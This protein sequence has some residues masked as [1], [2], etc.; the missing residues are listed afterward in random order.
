MLAAAALRS[1][2]FLF[3]EPEIDPAAIRRHSQTGS[4]YFAAETAGE[5]VA[6]CRCWEE[7]G[8]LWVGALAA[9]VP[10]A[11]R[12]VVDAAERHAQD[13]GLRWVR[14]AFPEE[15]RAATLLRQ[16]G[17]QVVS[18]GQMETPAGEPWTRLVAEKRLRLLTVRPGRRGDEDALDALGAA[19]APQVCTVALDGDRLVGAVAVQPSGQTDALLGVPVLLAGYEG[20]GLEAWMAEVAARTQ[21]MA[22]RYRLLAPRDSYGDGLTARGW[23]EEGPYYVRD[24]G[25]VLTFD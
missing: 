12:A 11:G 2:A 5:V 25:E 15:S 13:A 21:A 22:G 19:A 10:G 8:S 4:V 23:R 17:Y 9:A 3:V 20:R 18:R 1:P 16:W 7:D 14:I 6:T 24:L